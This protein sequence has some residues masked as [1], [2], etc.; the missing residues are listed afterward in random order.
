MMNGEVEIVPGV[1][2]PEVVAYDDNEKFVHFGR[3]GKDEPLTV[4]EV[5]YS[6]RFD[7]E[8]KRYGCDKL[9]VHVNPATSP[10]APITTAALRD[11]AI[12]DAMVVKLL[13]ITDP[14]NPVLR[15]LPNPDGREPWG[16]TPPDGLAKEGPTNRALHWVAHIYRYAV[17]VSYPP[18]KAVEESIKLTRPTAGRWI[19]AARQSD[20]LGPAEV[21]KAGG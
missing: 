16:R 13:A 7:H 6:F 17:A 3:A 2:G 19:A 9:T 8:S 21:G 12:R 5:S 20:L 18:T 4:F 11:I 15:D 14:D 10:T 1:V